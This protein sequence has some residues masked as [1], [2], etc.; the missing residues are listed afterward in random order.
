MGG[1]GAKAGCGGVRRRRRSGDGQGFVLLP[2]KSRAPAR[3]VQA[4]H[5]RKGGPVARGRGGNALNR[6]QP[7]FTTVGLTSVLSTRERKA[8][9]V[10]RQALE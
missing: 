9:T 2:H 4:A 3:S 10:V 6:T 7:S 1:V 5:R 8:S